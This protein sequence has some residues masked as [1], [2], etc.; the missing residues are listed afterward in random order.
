M[1]SRFATRRRCYCT[2]DTPNRT[3]KEMISQDRPGIRRYSSNAVPPKLPRGS[4]MARNSGCWENGV[5]APSCS[6]STR[7]ESSSQLRRAPLSAD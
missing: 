7:R 5:S 1:H 4:S 3:S 6:S 2:S